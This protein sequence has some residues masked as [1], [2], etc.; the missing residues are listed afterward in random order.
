MDKLWSFSE[1]LVAAALERQDS[2][3]PSD[4]I[5]VMTSR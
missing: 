1:G 3:Q 4:H 2:L 5:L